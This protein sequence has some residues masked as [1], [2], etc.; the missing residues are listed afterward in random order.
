MMPSGIP[1]EVDVVVDDLGPQLH[2]VEVA[3]PANQR[4]ERPLHPVQP[5]RE[6]PRTLVELQ[7]KADPA[8]LDGRIDA[9]HVG[10]EEDLAVAG[11]QETER[12]TDQPPVGKAPPGICGVGH[13]AEQVAGITG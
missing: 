1:V 2:E 13:R 11:A 8:A 7:S 10:V 12:A 4:V 3:V 6:G 5:A 9:R